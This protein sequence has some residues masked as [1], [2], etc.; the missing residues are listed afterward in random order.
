MVLVGSVVFS[1]E[2]HN[3]PFVSRGEGLMMPNLLEMLASGG[4]GRP[5]PRPRQ[6]IRSSTQRATQA[7]AASEYDKPLFERPE[8]W[9]AIMQTGLGMLAGSS[10]FGATG[11]SSFGKAASQFGL[12]AYQQG[13]RRAAI[14]DAMTGAPE[15]MQRLMSIDPELAMQMTGGGSDPRIMSGPNGAIYRIGATGDPELVVPGVP[16]EPNLTDQQ[17]QFEEYKKVNPDANIEDFREWLNSL[18]PEDERSYTADEQK[19]LQF[20]HMLTNPLDEYGQSIADMLNAFDAPGVADEMI[21]TFLT[22]FSS[23]EQR[24]RTALERV[25]AD[26]VLRIA[27][28]ATATRAEIDDVRETYFPRVRDDRAMIRMKAALRANWL[29]SLTAGMQ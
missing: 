10:D 17:W 12:P 5:N 23:Q 21:E 22:S 28:G 3:V 20:H 14:S 18:E 2:G 16:D 11:L 4:P 29:R 27:T 24:Q 7:P 25:F 1:D 6:A 13:R 8:L 19:R 9:N 26:A 15:A